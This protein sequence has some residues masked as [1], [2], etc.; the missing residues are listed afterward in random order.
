MLSTH[1]AFL[2]GYNTVF[3][4]VRTVITD[5]GESDDDGFGDDGVMEFAP[6][7]D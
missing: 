6:D 4:A 2:A 7:P 3:E 5:S 1:E